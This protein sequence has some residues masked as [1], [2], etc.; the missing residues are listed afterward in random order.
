MFSPFRQASSLLFLIVYCLFTSQQVSGV[1][2]TLEEKGYLN[3][4][5]EIR[6]CT[7]VDSMPL[8]DVIDGK[9]IGINAE[10]M[11]I[12]ETFI[13][14]PIVLH[15]TSS[16]YNSLLAVKNGECEIIALAAKTPQ[17]EAYLLFTDS[18][19]SIPFVVVTTQEKF[20]ISRLSE[21]I[22]K[23]LTLGVQ[24]GYAY[25][26]LLKNKHPDAILIEVESTEEALEK[27][28]RGEIFGFLTGLNMAGY[29]I[30][31]GGY[32]NL[33]ING[34]F[35]ELSV[36][37]LGI[38]VRKEMPLLKDIFNKAISSVPA[39]VKKRVDNSWLS[40]RYEIVE[41]YQRLIQFSVV[42]ATILLFLGYRQ[43]H[44]KRLN[45]KLEDREKAIWRQANFDFLTELP[46]RRLFQ[47]RLSQKLSKSMRS[48]IS[49]ALMLID[50]DGFKEINDTWGHD[51]GDE[52]LI[53]TAKRIKD[54]LRKS[55]TIARLGGDEFVVLL[56]DSAQGMNVE[57]VAQK[58]LRALSEPFNLK[59]QAFVSASI[60]ITLCP[61]DGNNMVELLKN[62]DQA[63][64][65]AKDK[66]RNNFHYFTPEMQATAVHRMQMISELRTA[67]ETDQFEVFYQPIVNLKTQQFDK[68]EALLRWRHPQ[69]GLVSPLDFIPILEETG[70]INQVGR[71]VFIQAAKQAANIRE[72][73]NPAFQIS[74]NTSPIQ[75]L[76]R[77]TFGFVSLLDDLNIPPSAV[78]IEITEST[79]MEQVDL[80]SQHLFDLR[81]NG[82]QVSLDDFGTGYSSL[83]YLK[84]FDIDYLKIDKSFVDNLS[85]D[86]NDLVLCE[87]MI[88][89][90]HKIGLS[91]IAEGVEDSRQANLLKS[92]NCDFAQGYHFARPLD[93][94]QLVEFLQNHT[95][96]KNLTA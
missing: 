67:I 44:L 27:V 96:P 41:D 20:F 31:Q 48:Q 77:S 73:V 23:Q 52:M 45:A 78:A 81:D 42:A 16:W 87:A 88:V 32:T 34:Q 3:S 2:L 29:S 10:Y 8:D 82:V 51:Q 94:Q 74:I 59:E 71:W 63:M 92:V 5:G 75:Y 50:L 62:A 21:L 1:T 65:A 93:E 66:G 36:I 72:W 26:D 19:V 39:E 89:M 54:C 80:V 37:Q 7:A 14:T 95:N 53:E 49:F 6:L 35:D 40:I 70:L 13:Q 84:K 12:F 69:K 61:R 64:Y 22:E 11:R 30:Q 85:A 43:Y 33:K 86:S 46:N 25:V 15:E 79:L 28:S 58:I 57:M 76:S 83:A 18:Y 90:A 4:L 60:G 56:D 47:D 24:K 55:D 38:G 68:A 9:H 91:V 17:R